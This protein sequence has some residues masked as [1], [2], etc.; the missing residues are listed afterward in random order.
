M[1]KILGEGYQYKWTVGKPFEAELVDRVYGRGIPWGGGFISLEADGGEADYIREHFSN[2]PLTDFE[3]VIW[4][5]KR[6]VNFI[7]DN[8]ALMASRFSV[9]KTGRA[10]VG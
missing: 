10:T 6:T 2:I 8:L 9:R 4:T 7:T 5:D 1:L 3:K